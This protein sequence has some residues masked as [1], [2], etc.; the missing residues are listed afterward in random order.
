[1]EVKDNPTYI[2]KITGD[3]DEGKA[4]LDNF[5]SVNKKFPTIAVTS[6]LMTTGVDAKMCKLIV[7]DKEVN[8][9]IIFK[10]MIGRGTRIREEDGKTYFTIMDFRGVSRLFADPE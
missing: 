5:I 8:S 4:Q 3:D 10:Q 7:I 1:M 9:Q 2:M 6:E